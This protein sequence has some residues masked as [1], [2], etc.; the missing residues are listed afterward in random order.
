M[1]MTNSLLL[2]I[3][4]LEVWYKVYE[5][6]LEVLNGVSLDVSEGERIGLIG[7]AGC[8][9][10]TLLNTVA[11][12]LP[13]PPAAVKGGEARFRGR[14]L[15][16]G[17][18]ASH[19]AIRRDVSMILQ[20]P[21]ASLNPTLKVRTF[22]A[23]ILKNRPKRIS[24][25]E[26]ARL[27]LESL[28]QVSMPSPD[29]V[30]DSYP[31]QL[32]GGMRQRVCIAMSLLKDVT[33]LL[34]DEP[35]TSL[36]VTIERQ[37][38]RLLNRLMVD[39]QRSLILVS[40]ALGA[41]RT[42]TDRTYVMYAGEIAESGPTQVV[43]QQAAHPYA[44]GLFDATPKLSGEGVSDGIAGD[45]PSYLNPPAGCRFAPRCPRVMPICREETPGAIRLSEGHTVFCWAYADEQEEAA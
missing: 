33:L 13:I 9:K 31:V 12:I 42:M 3:D 2:S 32:S 7:E 43:F 38:L 4:S 5:G 34:A 1:M 41:I 40:H 29:R 19:R 26:R 18:K 39:K 24:K 14:N 27:M 6:Y 23:D 45:L 21:T 17:T 37:I 15:L 10:T 28:E 11:R 30:L 8:G 16:D 36:D 22:M 20:D 25:K 35:T 44:Q